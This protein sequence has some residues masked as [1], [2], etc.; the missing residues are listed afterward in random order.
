MNYILYGELYP[1]IRKH[2]NKILKDRLENPDDFN[3]VKVD[4]EESP[5]DEVIYEASSLPL[6]YDKKVVVVDNCNFLT[7]DVEEKDETK[8]LNL[9][10]QNTDEIDLVFILRSEKVDKNGNIDG[11]ETEKG[12]E[13]NAPK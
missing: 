9:L 3:V 1:M 11:N 7:K 5:L 2:L 10:S 13:E 8:V 12:I 6:G 4:L